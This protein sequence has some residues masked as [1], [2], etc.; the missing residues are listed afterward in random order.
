MIRRNPSD[1]AAGRR[2]AFDPPCQCF[3]RRI[4]SRAAETPLS[5][6]SVVVRRRHSNLVVARIMTFSRWF[7]C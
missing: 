6:L 3:T 2:N 1:A 4:R 5:M 7:L